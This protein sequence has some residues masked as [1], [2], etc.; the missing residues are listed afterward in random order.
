MVPVRHGAP[1]RA[2]GLV[3][4][5]VD[6]GCQQGAGAQVRLDDDHADRLALVIH[7]QVGI[8]FLPGQG[9]A[10][11]HAALCV[12]RR[13]QVGLEA[14]VV[15]AAH[16]EAGT[17]LELLRRPL[18]YHVD[19]GR[20]VARAAHQAR[21]AAHDFDAVVQNR[22]LQRR[23]AAARHAV[24]LE[25]VDAEA[26]RIKPRALR[27]VL[28]HLDTRRLR[29]RLVQPHGAQVVEQLARDDADRLRRFVQG[30]LHARGAARFA[31][32]VRLRAFRRRG[33]LAQHG[34]GRHG[35]VGRGDI[36]GLCR[37][38]HAGRKAQRDAG[39]WSGLDSSSTARPG[40]D[41]QWKGR[42][43]DSRQFREWESL[44]I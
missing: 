11:P 31:C 5:E 34:D 12:Q 44:S 7:V 43:R 2:R 4:L 16:D 23:I 32:R 8:A 28:A 3:V 17:G 13:G 40:A 1:G 21:G 10:R 41:G 22:V 27:V 26:A 15:P 37:Q 33:R 35:D 38:G 36:G 20:R 6:A 25:I 18:A 39:P 14:L 19:G 29:Q 42:A 9:R 30:Q 24:D